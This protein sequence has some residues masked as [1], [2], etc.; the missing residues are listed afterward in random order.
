MKYWGHWGERPELLFLDDKLI[1]I[2]REAV[3]IRG[4]YYIDELYT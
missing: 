4:S 2:N 3:E 1:S